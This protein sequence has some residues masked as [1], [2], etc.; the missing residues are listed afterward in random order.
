MQHGRILFWGYGCGAKLVTLY[1]YTYIYVYLVNTVLI[2]IFE[3][4]RRYKNSE[5]CREAATRHWKACT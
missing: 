2:K 5:C 3:N 4:D 1:I